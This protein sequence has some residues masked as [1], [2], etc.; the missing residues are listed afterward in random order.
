MSATISRDRRGQSND[1]AGPIRRRCLQI[2]AMVVPQA[3]ILS[4][5]SGNL[6][7]TGSR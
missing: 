3:A 4:D 6:S 2:G 1:M 5:P 7:Y